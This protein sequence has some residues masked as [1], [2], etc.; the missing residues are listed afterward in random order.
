MKRII[1]LT[2]C[3]VSSL[4]GYS[5]TD[6][7]TII[8]VAKFTTEVNS[9]FS[10]SVAEKVVK[11]VTNSKR[12][13]V[14][15]RTSYD[16]IKQELEFQKTEAF[17]DSKNT[18]K[19]DVALAAQF[20]ILGHI[21]KM[22]VYGMKNTDGTVNGYKASVAFTLKVNDVET[23]NTTEAVSFQTEVSPLMLS[24]E[25]AVNEALKSI[26]PNLTSY[27]IKTFP[28]AT[29]ISKIL[30]S[31]KESAAT[32]LIAGGKEYGF[33]EGDKLIVEK[34]EMIDGKPYPSEI[35]ELKIV[36]IAGDNFSECLV[37][38]GGKEILARFNSAER[39]NCKLIVK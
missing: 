35:G 21:I 3:L 7:K 33:K 12:F 9:K 31:K 32:V 20:L 17:I 5:Q 39:L 8:G 15:D 29:K 38:E 37:S 19:Q 30:T 14:V 16:K 34:N 26:E 13:I 18:A 23:F 2:I 25:S 27:F 24:P 22:N 10:E 1:T 36:K 28:L 6:S 11:I 4:I